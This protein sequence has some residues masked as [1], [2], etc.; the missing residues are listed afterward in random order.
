MCPGY[1]GCFY[2]TRPI[3]KC[4]QRSQKNLQELEYYGKGSEDRLTKDK[5]CIYFK[6]K[7][8]VAATWAGSVHR[9]IPVC[10]SA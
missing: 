6:I 9:N 7:Q 4:S 2:F 1:F 5:S 8:P 3:N 10:L